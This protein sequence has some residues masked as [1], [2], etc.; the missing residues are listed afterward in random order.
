M[1]DVAPGTYTLQASKSGYVSVTRTITLPDDASVP[2]SLGLDPEYESIKKEI[3]NTVSG[4]DGPCP[5][6]HD[7]FKCFAYGFPAHHARGI[8]A[9]LYWHSSDARLELELRCNGQ[10]W[11]RTEGMEPKLT[12]YNREEYYMFRILEDAKK[13]QMCEIRVLHLSGVT[14][15]F[16]LN[17][18]HPN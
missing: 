8:E 18:S 5:G 6:S 11:V 1:A 13:G 14:M 17:V 9:Y 3:T 12:E 7:N 16:I 15:P 4:D 10:T 2:F